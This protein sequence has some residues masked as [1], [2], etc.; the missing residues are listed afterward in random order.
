[1]EERRAII[2]WR[3]GELLYAGGEESHYALE[4]RRAIMRWRRGEPLCAGEEE[5]HYALEERKLMLLAA[6]AVTK[7]CSPHEYEGLK[8]GPYTHS[9]P[10]KIAATSKLV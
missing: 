6:L 7:A 10:Q 9:L 1:M 2:R 8:S 3:R 5:S 4:E